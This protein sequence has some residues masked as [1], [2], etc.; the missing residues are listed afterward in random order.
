MHCR[1][2]R[3]DA[4]LGRDSSVAPIQH[5]DLAE[6]SV[7]DAGAIVA[8]GDQEPLQRLAHRL[9]GEFEGRVVNGQKE[10]RAQ[11]DEHAPDLFGRGVHVVPGVV[12]AD[13]ES[14]E[15]DGTDRLC[16][17]GDLFGVGGIAGENEGALRVGER[18]AERAAPSIEDD[19]CAPVACGQSADLKIVV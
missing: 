5:G 1:Q 14:R 18:V 15:I 17:T 10:P 3:V 6:T 19:A 16:G 2:S 13:A 9:I 11:A 12:R 8:R 7:Q 4:G